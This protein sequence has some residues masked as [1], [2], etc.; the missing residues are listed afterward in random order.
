M[1]AVHPT[2]RVTAGGTGTC[3]GPCHKTPQTLPCPRAKGTPAAPGTERPASSRGSRGGHGG[4]RQRSRRPGTG[5]PPRSCRSQWSARSALQRA[6]A[7]VEQGKRHICNTAH[8]SRLPPRAWGYLSSSS[9]SSFSLPPHV[10]AGCWS[11]PL[12]CRLLTTSRSV[13]VSPLH[14]PC[15]SRKVHICPKEN[16]RQTFVGWEPTTLL[17]S[18]QTPR[19]MALKNRGKRKDE[20]PGVLAIR[21][22]KGAVHPDPHISRGASG[23]HP[24][25]SVSSSP[26][27]VPHTN[28]EV[29]QDAAELECLV[30]VQLQRDALDACGHREAASEERT[31]DFRKIKHLAARAKPFISFFPSN[32]LNSMSWDKPMHPAV[33]TV[34]GLPPA[35]VP[36]GGQDV[37]HA[38]AV[39][40]VRQPR[41]APAAFHAPLEEKE[42][43]EMTGPARPEGKTPLQTPETRSPSAAWTHR[44]T[45][46]I[47]KLVYERPEE[48]WSVRLT[49]H[50]TQV[51]PFIPR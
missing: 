51:V 19:G 38:V 17:C 12:P 18:S 29:K 13:R 49:I 42:W 28:P 44:G 8:P 34:L 3:G 6:A 27:E 50:R 39:V 2:P 46:G 15:C 7:T 30:Q 45:N 40:G 33:L 35:R 14:Q 4:R 31:A 37:L 24:P 21:S 36:G 23:A 25:S 41:V 20:D 10:S 9:S 26:A 1:Q 16:F 11:N 48:P 5:T 47:S 22:P 43:V 32:L